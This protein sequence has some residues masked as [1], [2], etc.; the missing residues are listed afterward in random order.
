MFVG[1]H[2]NVTGSWGRNFV[3]KLHSVYNSGVIGNE[4]RFMGM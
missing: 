3:C 1:N 2:Q 4:K